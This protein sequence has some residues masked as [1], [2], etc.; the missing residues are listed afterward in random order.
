MRELFPLGS[1]EQVLMRLRQH[2]VI[3]GRQALAYLFFL[4]LPFGLW[5]LQQRFLP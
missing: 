3:F 4:A 1:S 5:W 2:W